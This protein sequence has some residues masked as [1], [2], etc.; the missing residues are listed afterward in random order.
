[1]GNAGLGRPR[2]AV[3]ERLTRPQRLVRQL[4]DLDSGRLRRL[5]RSGDLAPCFDADDDERAVECPICFYFY[6]SLNQSKCC[7]KGIC[8]ECFLQLMPSKASKAVQYKF[9]PKPQQELWNEVVAEFCIP[10][11]EFPG[12][13]NWQCSCPFCKTATYAVEYCGAR[14]SSDN[15]LRQEEEQ[16]INE[17]KTRIRPKTQKT[18]EV[19]S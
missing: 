3:E 8:T 14:T 15:K 10:K 6:P 7:G 13:L 2:P 12:A 17:A 19:Q 9:E 18:V 4:S 1:M 11:T 5:I 16:N